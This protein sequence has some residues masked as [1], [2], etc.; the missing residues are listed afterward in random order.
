MS[1]KNTTKPSLM[2]R[3]KN[4]LLAKKARSLQKKFSQAKE[5]L[6]NLQD[7]SKYEQ[8]RKSMI[9]ARNAYVTFLVKHNMLPEDMKDSV[10]PRAIHYLEMS[11]FDE[12]V[13]K[14]VAACRQVK[15]QRKMEAKQRGWFSRKKKKQSADDMILQEQ[16]GQEKQQNY[17]FY[18]KLVE[19]TKEICRLNKWFTREQW[20]QHGVPIN[21]YMKALWGALVEY[22]DVRRYYTKLEWDEKTRKFQGNS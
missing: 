10:I 1:Q 16:F 7:I 14:K 12:S 11:E 13:A 2:A 4:N 22:T 6:D 20:Q 9:N 15:E 19:V 8:V 5:R 3:I 17:F 21:K 18:L